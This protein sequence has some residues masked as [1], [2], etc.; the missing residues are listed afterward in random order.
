MQK[1]VPGTSIPLHLPCPACSVITRQRLL[2]RK[3]GCAILRC[4]GCGIGR[5]ETAGFDPTAYYTD[6]YFSGRHA[7]GYADYR[8]AEPVL[9]R[10]FSRTVDFVRRF[11]DG[12]RLIEAGCAYGFFLAEAARHYEVAGVE[13]AEEAAAFCRDRGL[14][15][16]T[17]VVA[18]DTLDRLGPADVVVMLDVIEHLPA[19]EE[20]LALLAGRLTRGGI[21]VLTTGDFGSPV[22]RLAG[23]GWRL[24][25]PPQHLWFF[26]VA[27]VR[28]LAERLGLEL[29][30]VDH[31][32]KIVPMSLILHQLG[33]MT[34]LGAR[35]VPD[36]VPRSV[37]AASR[38]G[39]PVNLFDAMRVVLRKP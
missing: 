11:R 15:V 32:G 16:I 36:G 25:T 13:I 28:R 2:Y 30:H 4:E 27:S 8:G 29:A 19:P 12:G 17:G 21:V 7:D 38:L 5:T 10:E 24:M 39:L 9:R 37:P 35:S 18:P 33:R 34:G 1:T 14:D 3:H 26:T 6:G 23:R 22:A 20:T 31:P